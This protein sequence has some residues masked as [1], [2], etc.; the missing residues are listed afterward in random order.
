MAVYFVRI[1]K[2]IKIGF[3]TEMVGIPACAADNN[4]IAERWKA[5]YCRNGVWRGRDGGIERSKEIYSALLSLGT[6]PTSV[7]I[8]KIIG[9]DTVLFAMSAAKRHAVAARSAAAEA[10]F[11]RSLF[12]AKKKA[13]TWDAGPFKEMDKHDHHKAQ[14]LRE[15]SR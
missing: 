8:N 14:R 1:G 4:K 13:P 15:A 9:N 3:T 7:E 5:Q 6:N 11:A 12:P 2:F 10:A